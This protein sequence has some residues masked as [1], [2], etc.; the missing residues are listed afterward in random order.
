MAQSHVI[1][2]IFLA[3]VSANMIQGAVILPALYQNENTFPNFV[4]AANIPRFGELSSN[5]ASSAANT[6]ATA[7]KGFRTYVDDFRTGLGQYVTIP[8]RY[9]ALNRFVHGE[10]WP[11]FAG[12]VVAPGNLVAPG[13]SRGNGGA[14]AA[15]AASSAASGGR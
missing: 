7:F 14:A 10:T 4:N 2:A 11:N 8:P 1:S 5:F 12:P 6:A 13:L 15:S 9:G 3:F